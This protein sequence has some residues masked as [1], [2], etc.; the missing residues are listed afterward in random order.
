MY[1]IQALFAANQDSDA[2]DEFILWQC[3]HETF[4]DNIPLVQYHLVKIIDIVVGENLQRTDSELE[5]VFVGSTASALKREILKARIQN[6]CKRLRKVVKQREKMIDFIY[7]II[8]Y[9]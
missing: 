8:F 4:C 1:R 2:N 3:C 5:Q 6:L 7:F 9:F